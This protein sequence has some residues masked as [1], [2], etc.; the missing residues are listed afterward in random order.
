MNPMPILKILLLLLRSRN[1]LFMLPSSCLKML[2]QSLLLL[3][4]SW[5]LSS[6][7]AQHKLYLPPPIASPQ[8][9]FWIYF[10]VW[11]EG[12]PC[13]IHSLG[14]SRLEPRIL[15]IMWADI[16]RKKRFKPPNPLGGWGGKEGI[17]WKRELYT[18]G[19][20]AS[21]L[22]HIFKTVWVHGYW[23]TSIAN[24]SQY[25]VK[26]VVSQHQCQQKSHPELL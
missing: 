10:T 8:I 2:Q 20:L 26:V 13:C 5:R 17:L 6:W 11:E 23:G 19:N 16:R 14:R 18:L 25:A 7:S 21:H 1:L 24:P 9:I 12:T 4:F 22:K 3:D 15:Y